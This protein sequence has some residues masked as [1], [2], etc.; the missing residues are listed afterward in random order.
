MMLK[1]KLGCPQRLKKSENLVIFWKFC[2]QP[3]IVPIVCRA[4]ARVG[5]MGNPSDGFHGKTIS[6]SI[7]NFWAE[8]TIFE[9]ERLH[10]GHNFELFRIIYKSRIICSKVRKSPPSSE[11]PDFFRLT[12]R[13]TRY[14]QEGRL[15]GRPTTCSR[16]WSET[17][18]ARI[19]H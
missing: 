9:S 7:S 18:F 4:Y 6:L 13:F 14:F 10:L 8:A 1:T 12:C 11:W 15:H 17:F 3:K 16:V 19:S 2:R 5:L